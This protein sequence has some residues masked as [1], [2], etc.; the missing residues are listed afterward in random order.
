VSSHTL[1]RRA[2]TFQA[3]GAID[4]PESDNLLQAL[5]CDNLDDHL[6]AS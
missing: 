6:Q 1:A 2:D 5:L 4:T 3:S